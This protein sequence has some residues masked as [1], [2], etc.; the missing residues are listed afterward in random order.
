MAA[1][2]LAATSITAFAA[3]PKPVTVKLND[4][5][6]KDVGT[7][8]FVSRGNGVDLRIALHDLPAGEHAVH[9]HDGG[10]CTP[11]DF[12][13]A[14]GHFN[15]S[16][17]HHGYQ[18]PEGHHAGDLPSSVEVKADGKGKAT[19]LDADISLDPASTSAVYGKTVMVHE[20]KDDQKTDPAGAAGKRIACGVI[21]AAAM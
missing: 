8:T 11:P 14:Q 7:V 18:N 9:V 1:A 16:N 2:A 6:G 10:S 15:P 21:P 4:P 19:L 13:S 20:L 5:N 17:K 3:G 12:T